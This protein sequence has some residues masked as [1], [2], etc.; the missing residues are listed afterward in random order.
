MHPDSRHFGGIC[1][2]AANRLG[3]TR[4]VVAHNTDNSTSLIGQDSHQFNVTG[5]TNG[6]TVKRYLVGAQPINHAGKTLLIT[7]GVDRSAVADVNDRSSAI[8]LGLTEGSSRGLNRVHEVGVT[9]WKS[10]RKSVDARS[11]FTC[12][13]KAV[14]QFA[15]HHVSG[16]DPNTVLRTQAAND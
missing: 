10:L 5:R 16:I 1:D 9:K 7:H 15:R 3:G 13:G 12:R 6:N 2:A 4:C 14:G 11:G 8:G